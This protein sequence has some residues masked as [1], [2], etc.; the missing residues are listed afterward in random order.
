MASSDGHHVTPFK[1]YMV[2]YVSLLVLTVITVAI[3]RVE[4][5]VLNMPVAMLVASVKAALVVL[6]FMHQKYENNLNRVVF[7]SAFF[8]LLLM[9]GFTAADTFTREFFINTFGTQ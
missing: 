5:G 8:F 4:L 6:W 2:I 7:A 3:S 1:T 9:F